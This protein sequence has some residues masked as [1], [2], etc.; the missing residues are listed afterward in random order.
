MK[1]KVLLSKDE[2]GWREGPSFRPAAQFEGARHGQAYKTGD[3]GLGYYSERPAVWRGKVNLGKRHAPLH[4]IEGDML[5]V[6]PE[7]VA[8]ATFV[9]D[10][11]FDLIY[12]CDALVSLPPESWKQRESWQPSRQHAE[13]SRCI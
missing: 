2:Q 3:R 10:G 13:P 9:T 11:R 4:L 6:T 5:E 7:L 12:D 1:S 8:A